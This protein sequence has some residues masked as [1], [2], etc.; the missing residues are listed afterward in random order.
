M[1]LILVLTS[2]GVN[3]YISALS[4]IGGVGIYYFFIWLF[5]ERLAKEFVFYI[6]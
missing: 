4:A 5:R 3:E 1:L 2:L 6:R